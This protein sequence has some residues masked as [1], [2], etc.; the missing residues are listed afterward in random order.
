MMTPALGV[1]R[2]HYRGAEI[3]VAANPLVAELFRTHPWC[4]RILIFD[5]NGRHK[6]LAGLMTFTRELRSENFGLALLFQKA[7]EA[8]L[9]TFLA[10]IPIRAG[11]STD[12]RGFLLTHKTPLTEDIRQRHHSRH[13]LEMLAALGISGQD[14][15]L[16]LDLAPGEPSAALSLVGFD[17][18][19]VLNPGAAYGSAKRWYPERFA[20]VG[21]ILSRRL[22]LGVVIIGGPGETAIGADIERQLSCPRINLVGRTS[23]R[24][25]MAVIACS[26]LVVS[27]DSGPMH[28]AAAFSVPT[29]AIFGPTD[30]T[31]T[32]PLSEASRVVHSAADCAPCLRRTCPTDHHCMLNVT[33][34][35]V[36]S[37]ALELL[38]EGGDGLRRG[39]GRELV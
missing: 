26:R 12:H 13:Y 15:P 3:V 17:G 22:G 1:V 20:A 33:V 21:N 29:V 8:A 19:L 10:G 11:F 28:I 36:V 23:V 37:A 34:D 14:S 24:E 9:L 6:G 7:F 16:R 18:W 25:M 2:Q 27:N 32:Y 30:H 38:E 39:A 5:K 4:D 35:Q 31:T